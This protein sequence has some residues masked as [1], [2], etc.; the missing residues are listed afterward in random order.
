MLVW[1]STLI[2]SKTSNW[3][4]VSILLRSWEVGQNGQMDWEVGQ[5]GQT[6]PNIEIPFQNHTITIHWPSLYC[7][8]PFCDQDD[9]QTISGVQFPASNATSRAVQSP[10]PRMMLG[11]DQCPVS[12]SEYSDVQFPMSHVR[13]P[14]SRTVRCPERCPEMSSVASWC[15]I[16]NWGTSPLPG[17][18]PRMSGLILLYRNPVVCSCS[19]LYRN[20]E[21]YR[22]VWSWLG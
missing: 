1:T 4:V 8:K 9:K 3:E 19:Y 6:R 14:M 2:I 16:P 7:Y 18:Y 17:L 20:P 22:I 5:V 11:D 21:G 12:S 10:V 13:C 15:S